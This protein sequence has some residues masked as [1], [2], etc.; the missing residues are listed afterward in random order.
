MST[1]TQTVQAHP[2]DALTGA[3]AAVLRHHGV[4]VDVDALRTVA[5]RWWAYSRPNRVP[6]GYTL[7]HF[8]A[9]PYDC[10]STLDVLGAEAA[11]D[12][13]DHTVRGGVRG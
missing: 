1:P 9:L 11:T 7:G 2:A 3:A 10:A 13:Q 8:L 6:F 4:P 12:A 5:R